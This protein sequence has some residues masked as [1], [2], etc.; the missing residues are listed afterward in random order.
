MAS[1]LSVVIPVYKSTKEFVTNLVKNK[2]F[3]LPH[4]IIIVNDDPTASIEKEIKKIIP[5]A[6]VIQN[7]SNLGFGKSVNKGV[8]NASSEYV[9]LLN[10]DV[11]LKDGSFLNALGVFNKN[12]NTFAVSF[13]QIEKN[14]NVVGANSGYFKNGMYHHKGKACSDFCE[15]L[16][17]EGGSCIVSKKKYL[18]LGGFDKDYSPFYWE[19]VDLGYRAKRLGYKTFF[20]PR[21]VVNHNHE[22]TIGKHFTKAAVQKIAYR[23]QFLFIWK[24]IR[25]L[26]L[27]KHIIYLPVILFKNRKNKNFINGFLNAINRFILKQ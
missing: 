17:P 24:N 3:L 11:I 14:G 21:I 15:T 8:K 18:E 22:T 10:S 20:D 9:M 26:D 5:S 13:A 12:K 2:S 4:E 27:V 16:W 7:T 23:N 1:N 25:G 19:D 6:K